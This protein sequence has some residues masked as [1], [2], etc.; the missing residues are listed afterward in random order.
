MG[1]VLAIYIFA[2]SAAFA[3]T[4]RNEYVRQYDTVFSLRPSASLSK[5]ALQIYEKDTDKK[6]VEYNPNSLFY[7]GLDLTAGG[8]GFGASTAIP[9]SG[10]DEE[11]HGESESFDLQTYYYSTRIGIDLFYQKYEGFYAEL[12]ETSGFATDV[13]K[14]LKMTNYGFN[15]YYVFSDEFSLKAA[16]NQTEKQ[17]KTGVSFLLGASSSYFKIESDR[18]LIP[19]AE[20]SKVGDFSGYHGGEYMTFALMPGIG[21]T[22]LPENIYY[23]T[24]LAMMGGGVAYTK[25]DTSSGRIDRTTDIFK[26]NAKYGIG[27]NTDVFFAGA[28]IVLDLTVTSWFSKSTIRLGTGVMFLEF[29]AGV[30]I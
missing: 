14:D 21:I 8:F 10:K 15:V 29:F 26:V 28:S 7:F 22:Y 11:T 17:I 2:T 19:S 27:L 18:S 30:R 23:M 16:F 1:L 20:E 24:F 13:R 25:N 12:G 9:G 3:E 4:D 6:I 5:L